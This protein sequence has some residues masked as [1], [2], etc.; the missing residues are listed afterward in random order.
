VDI[1]LAMTEQL[2]NYVAKLGVPRKRIIVCPLGVDTSLFRPDLD[3]S[4]LRAKH[5]IHE[6]DKVITF[7]GSLP[8]FSGVKKF[9]RRFA[10]L[11]KEIP[12]VK[13]CI[14]GEGAQYQSIKNEISKQKLENDVI[15]TGW[16]NYK[17]VPEY[18]NLANVCLVPF[19]IIPA[20]IDITP[21]KILQYLACAKPVVS[22]ALNGTMHLLP[23]EKSGV[24]YGKNQ[25]ELITHVERILSNENYALRL[26]E[27]GRR[28][29]DKNFRWE[30][31]TRQI[32]KIISDLVESS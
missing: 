15:M 5:N 7:V 11:K 29:V 25:G 14:V 1:V 4:H 21:T 24:L 30:V 18:I 31:I 10:K 19:D 28:M 12:N 27:N 23:P 20:T 6:D 26:K 2:G 16:V 9:V 8:D 17:E 32:E 13:F 22:S 3:V